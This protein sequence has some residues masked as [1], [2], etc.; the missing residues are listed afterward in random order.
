M[1]FFALSWR[2]ISQAINHG[3]AWEA[4]V[5]SVIALVYMASLIFK[6]RQGL[7]PLKTPGPWLVLL[8]LGGLPWSFSHRAEVPVFE[9]VKSEK[10][11]RDKPFAIHGIYPGMSREEVTEKLGPA[12]GHEWVYQSKLTHFNAGSTEQLLGK[13]FFDLDLDETKFWLYEDSKNA[14]R[15]QFERLKNRLASDLEY[16]EFTAAE[17]TL[18]SD[19]L[20]TDI[21]A[22]KPLLVLWPDEGAYN[23]LQEK[24]SQRSEE[25]EHQQNS[26]L[27]IWSDEKPQIIGGKR[28]YSTLFETRRW[29]LHTF[30]QPGIALDYVPT[31][32]YSPEP[33]KDR[34]VYEVDSVHGDALSYGGKTF[35]R[36]GEAFE[37][38]PPD[39]GKPKESY[40]QLFNVHPS[41]MLK[42]CVLL[43]LKVSDHKIQLQLLDEKVRKVAIYN[44][45]YSK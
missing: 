29:K 41:D 12:T 31:T 17:R 38:F 22:T 30:K 40:M 28:T 4:G 1:A 35:I 11:W 26:V 45:R 9:T 27:I 7:H 20:V 14:L 5:V 18:A 39:W 2:F 10:S 24:L 36:A 8:L 42:A 3:R 21:L 23:E 13:V 19:E 32:V 16:K 37:R 15:E 43:D 44:L 33:G 25:S 6:G 34:K